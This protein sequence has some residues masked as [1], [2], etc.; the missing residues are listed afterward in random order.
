MLTPADVKLVGK[1]KIEL[2][3]KDKRL[4]LWVESPAKITLKTW[5]T[6]PVTDYDAE[7][8]GTVLVG[9]EAQLPANSR[10]VLQVRLVPGD[11]SV[12]ETQIQ[13]LNRWKTKR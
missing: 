5:S 8:P 7:N 11:K 4:T 3:Q 1:N 13:S 6:K 10:Q 2:R 12:T 9:F